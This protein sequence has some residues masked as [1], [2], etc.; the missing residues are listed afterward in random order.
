[1]PVTRDVLRSFGRSARATLLAEPGTSEAVRA[2]VEDFK[3]GERWAKNF[4]KRNH[5]QS[6][7]LHGEAGSVDKEAISEGMEEITAL[8]AKY[9]AKDVIQEWATI[10]DEDEVVQALRQDTVD[11]MTAQLARSRVSSREE[12]VEEEEEDGSGDENTGG[13]RRDPPPYG[14]LSP[15]FGVLE[16]AA[17]KSGNGDATFHLT[18]RWR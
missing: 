14:E 15:H 2:R 13:G 3:A 18:R 7:K 1:M 10:E 12:D 16:A 4:V 9:P 8:C 5:I 11:D 6:V 17:E